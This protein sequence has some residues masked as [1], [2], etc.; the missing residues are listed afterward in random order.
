MLHPMRN[1]LPEA[2]RDRPVAP[3]VGALAGGAVPGWRRSRILAEP[4]AP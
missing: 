1:L 2:E 4:P 3:L